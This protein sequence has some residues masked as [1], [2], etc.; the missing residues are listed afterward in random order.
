MKLSLANI[1][2]LTAAHSALAAPIADASDA[3]K[4]RDY[5]TYGDYSGKVGSYATYGDYGAPAGSAPPPASAP[6]SYGDYGTYAPPAGGYGKYS[7]YGTYKRAV[8]W[9]KSIFS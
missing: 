1:L 8:D 5:S 4:A 7:T 9:V 2:V 3:V 6:S